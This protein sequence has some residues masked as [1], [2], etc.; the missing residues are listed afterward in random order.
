MSDAIAKHLL[1]LGSE[2]EGAL[3]RCCGSAAF[4]RRMAAGLPYA[5]DAALFDAAER[6]W[7]TLQPEDWRE[8]FSHHPEI[9]GSIEALRERFA[10]TSAWSAGEQAGV[11]GAS[12]ATLAALAAG[13]RAYRE[14]FGYVFLICAT[15]RS[16][17]EMLAALRGRLANAP[18]DELRIAAAEQA[19]ITRLRLE[20]LCP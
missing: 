15:G 9:G 8:A 5:D 2:A 20:K 10:A 17:D 19:R 6:V 3:H 12:E 4:A 18:A 11:A 13:N 14:R 16:A 1:A 7:W